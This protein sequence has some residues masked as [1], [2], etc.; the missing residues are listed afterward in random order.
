MKKYLVTLVILLLTNYLF[1]QFKMDGYLFAYFEGSGEKNKQEQLRF[2]VSDDGIHWSALNGNQPVIA[3]GGISQTG[4]IRDPHILRGEN[5]KT[6]YLTATDMFTVKNGWDSNPG[7]VMLKSDDLINWTHSI[8]DLA[9]LYPKRFGNVKWVWAPQTIYDPK[10]KKYLVY[11]TIRFKGDDRLDFY[12]AYANK[13]FTG[14]EREP[15]LMFRAKYGAIDGDIIYKDGLYHFFYK[16]NTKDANGK[17]I[18]NGIQQATSRSLQG[19]WK[20]DFSYVDAYADKGVAVEGSSVFKLNDS[21]EYILMYDLYKDK[22]FEFQRSSDLEHFSDKPESFIKNFNPRHGSV[23]GITREEARRLQATWGGVPPYL[24]QPENNSDCYRFVSKGNPVITHHYTAD[25]AA[26][27]KGDTLWLFAGHDFVGGQKGYKM[28]DWLVFSTTDMVNWTEYPVP[29][30]IADF[31]WAKSGDAY[32]GQVI[33]R[34]GKYYWYVSTNWSGI[35]VAVSDRPE[36]PYKDA[37]GK[38]LLTNKDCFASTHSWAC[39]DPT[40]FIDDDGQAWLFWGNGE[41]YYA[42]LKEN[43]VEIDGEVK[44][45]EFEGFQFTEAPWIHKYNGKYYLSYATGFPEKIAYAIAD[46]IDGKYEYKG[47]INEIAGNSNTNHQS[48]VEF[49]GQ[50][51][52]VYHNGAIQTDGG[53]FSRSVCIDRLDYDPDGSIKRVKMTT[54]GTGASTAYLLTYFKDDTHGLYFALS[55]DGYT[56]TDVNNGQPVIAGD[57]IAE[58]K[59]IRDPHIMRGPDG[60]FYLAMTDLHI[61]GKQKGYRT[62]EWERPKELYQWGNN[63]GFVLMKSRDLIHWSHTVLDIYKAYPKWN[64]GCAWAPELI[65]DGDKGKIMIYFTMRKG[66]GR[67]KLYYA[68]M[69]E[70]FTALD[71]A[72]EILFEYPDTTKQVLDADI[73]K[74]PDGRFCM[75]YVAQENPGGIKMAFSDRINGGYVYQPGQV[76]F[77]PGACEA[78]NVWKRGGTDKWVLMY[79]VFSV[80]PHN[81]GF[82]ETTDFVNFR[83]LGHFDEG[84][85]RRSNFSVQKHGAVICVTDEEARKLKEYWGMSTSDAQELKLVWSD[86]F[87]TEGRLDASIWNYENGFVRNEEAQWYQPENAYCKDGKLIIEARKEV[88]RQNPLFEAGSNDWRRKREFIEY[89]SSSVTTTGKKEFLYGRFEVRAKIPVDKGAWPAIWTLGR[90]MEWPSCGEIDLMEYYRINGVPH[91][92]ANA[93]WGT[94]LRYKAKWNSK[95][96]PFTHFTDKDLKWAEKFHVWR[97]DWDET[98][99]K[100]YLD[101][102]LLNEIPL[103]E[104]VNGS[105]G[106]GENPFT[107]PQYLLLNLAIGG[108]NGGPV[109]SA[110]LPMK[111]EIDYVRVYQKY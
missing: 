49:R 21:N 24:L 22:R 68:Y 89:T 15:K 47:I 45:L 31:T 99:L 37:L 85:M 78:P 101:D 92:L 33:E 111:Y 81:F 19:P 74:L 3:S 7:I 76:D 102:E 32:A 28:K 39:I 8:I 11:F 90:G 72:P 51:Y 18:K 60:W 65:Y 64:V 103:S 67:T 10:V 13:D 16:G 34:G 105:F 46:K 26:M 29:L 25:P 5:G 44:R 107:K 38:P 53:S 82:A 97:M 109:D 61:Y 88:G 93:A 54:E 83:N 70:E 104:T 20:E 14:F 1:S 56:F 77:E 71:S 110:A 79:D 52:F 4:G 66:N 69:N 59:G 84:V 95:K 63:R 87:N 58:Q 75:M 6:F 106:N 62:T 23:T 48:I 35:G 9:K 108:V 12:S 36:G 80:S 73:T 55:N 17:E 100:L 2:A 43:M 96:M 91:I 30:K 94:D 40:V 86:E 50:W 41:C 98:F 42:R 57:T 27:V